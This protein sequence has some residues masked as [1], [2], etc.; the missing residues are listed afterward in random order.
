V[1]IYPITVE[2]AGRTVA[3][4]GELKKSNR[5]GSSELL[6]ATRQG[7]VAE[8]KRFLISGADPNAEV[9]GDTPLV[10]AATCGK[11]EPVILLLEHGA[12][13]DRRD[14]I[15]TTPMFAATLNGNEEVVSALIAK[16]AEVD[17]KLPNGVTAIE[18]AEL[19][20]YAN[21]AKMLR[22]ARGK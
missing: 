7:D 20:S 17:A 12:E 16:G 21:I 8:M 19:K 14:A 3:R 2:R 18:M 4:S 13:V 1:T 9:N 6:S 10:I 5:S 22:D 11:R 15:G